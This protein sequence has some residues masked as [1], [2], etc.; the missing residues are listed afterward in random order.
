MTGKWIA[1]QFMVLG[2]ALLP[3]CLG[4]L[5]CRNTVF[6][7]QSS[8]YYCP[9]SGHSSLKCTSS[10]I[11]GIVLDG[12]PRAIELRTRPAHVYVPRKF[13]VTNLT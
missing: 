7:C 6:N 11:K 12:L 13:M 10:S 3:L 2:T 8:T 4:F 5:G 9:Y 1:L